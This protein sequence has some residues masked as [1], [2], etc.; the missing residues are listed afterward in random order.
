M[1]ENIIKLLSSPNEEDN[2]I[3][4]FLLKGNRKPHKVAQDLYKYCMSNTSD[5]PLVVKYIW[6]AGQSSVLK[7][8][9]RDKLI[10]PHGQNKKTP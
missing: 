1:T 4:L 3:G 5:I 6:F 2:I 9:W 8:H 7:G 10:K